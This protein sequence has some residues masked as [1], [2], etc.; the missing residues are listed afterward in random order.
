M[1]L[2]YPFRHVHMPRPGGEGHD[3]VIPS[4]SS[5][6]PSA[7]G[8]STARRNS[9]SAAGSFRARSRS[10]WA[11]PAHSVEEPPD[12]RPL[13]GLRHVH[14]GGGNPKALGPDGFTHS[15]VLL[16]R[17]PTFR[18]RAVHRRFGD[19][20]A[21]D[22][23]PVESEVLLHH[24]ERAHHAQS[25]RSGLLSDLAQRGGLGFLPG[26]TVPAGT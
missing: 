5:A 9:G 6:M 8:P 15:V 7:S 17:G 18:D 12:Q 13:A 26:R 14:G 25:A 4:S 10:P 22:L 21:L 1:I 19:M 23:E 11:R 2:A 3:P 16:G 20:A 24:T